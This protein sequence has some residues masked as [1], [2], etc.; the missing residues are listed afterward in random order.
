VNPYVIVSNARAAIDFYRRA[1]GAVER[2][3]KTNDEGKVLHAEVVIGD[4]GLMLAEE[5]EF[6]GV[7]AKSPRACGS[8]SMHLYLY[9]PD[10][11]GFFA[12]ATKAGAVEV[13]PISNQP[14]G[15][16]TGGVMDPFGHVW[17]LATVLE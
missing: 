6:R 7:V 8:T 1:F 9:V 4:S 13:M 12:T 16:R 3:I 14:Y 17:W 15:E 10:V 2:S 5:F 11:D